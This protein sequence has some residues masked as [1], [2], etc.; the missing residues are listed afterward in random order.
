MPQSH[1]FGNV[2]GHITPAIPVTA[3][4]VGKLLP[5]GF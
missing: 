4:R 1:F 2:D 3:E 5:I